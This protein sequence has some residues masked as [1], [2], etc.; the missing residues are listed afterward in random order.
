MNL[1]TNLDVSMIT[2]LFDTD[3]NSPNSIKKRAPFELRVGPFVNY[4]LEVLSF[5]GKER[6][7]DVYRYD[8]TFAT[9]VDEDTLHA[10]LFGEPGCLT[11]KAPGYD[12]RVI[13]G[14]V[15][16]VEGLGGV[17]GEQSTG[18]RRYRLEI[19]PKL[20]LMKQR[21][22]NRVFQQQSA[23]D[24]VNAMLT[25][26]GMQT[27]ESRWRAVAD[28]YPKLPFVYQRNE[29]DFD[30]FRRVLADAGIFFYFEHASALL[31]ILL[32]S[33]GAGVG[34]S[35]GGIGLSV[36]VSVGSS[37]TGGTTVLNFAARASDTPSVVPTVG[38]L[39]ASIGASLGVSVG[40]SLGVSVGA[41]GLSLGAEVDAGDGAVSDTITFDDGMG[42]D[43]G[44]DK[45]YEFGVK[46]LLRTK[47]LRLQERL[48]DT[49]VNW[50][51][52]QA[53][54]PPSS[55]AGLSVAPS[56]SVSIGL[57]GISASASVGSSPT[58]PF[59]LD[60]TA[61][62]P[63][64][65]RQERYQVDPSLSL[66]PSSGSVSDPR[67]ELEL[68]RTRRRY[69][70]AHGKSDC[71]RL[72]AGYRFTL[73]G[74]PIQALNEEY[75]V[76]SLD[77]HG[78]HPDYAKD[79]DHVYRNRFR[80]IPST[81]API[82]PRP[83]KRP[84]LGIEMAQVVAYSDI[85]QVPWLESSPN[86][87]VKIRFRWDIVDQGGA[88]TGMLQNGVQYSS[89][90]QD[91]FAI[92]V[93]VMQPWAGAG[94]GA[95]FIPRE[96]MEVVVGFLEDQGERPV[97]LGCMYNA[98][99]PPP[100]P[101]Q[102]DQ[103]KVGIKSQTRV[104][105]GGWSEVS[106]DDTQGSEDLMLRAQMDMTVNVL[107][108]VTTTVGN[109]VTTTIG[110]DEST[111][112]AVDRT[113][114]VGGNDTQTVTGNAARTVTGTDTLAV[115]GDAT[116]TI[117]GNVTCS[118][119]GTTT[120]TL[121]GDVTR[122]LCGDVLATTSGKTDQSFTLDYTERHQG[123]RTVIV[124]TGNAQRSS[125]LHVEGMGRAYASTSFEV[126]VLTGFTLVCGSS[127]ILVS[128]TGI[129]LSSPNITLSGKEVDALAGTFKANVS[130]ALTMMADTATLETSGAQIA[131]DSSSVTVEASAIKLGSGS[132]STSQTSAQPVKITKVQMKDSKGVPRA[133]TRV[134][135]VQGGKQRM[136]VLDADGMLE[137]IGDSS[138]QI[139]FPD[140]PQAK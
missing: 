128:P 32:P 111:S 50:V 61:V 27:S 21:R 6:V 41:G 110:N 74:Y 118:V 31:D 80:C 55:P 17:P 106:I 5:R 7:N 140:D 91:A 60:A 136:T 135:L 25:E 70:E 69:L 58:V 45:I 10:S 19:V 18:W 96:G 36:G 98:V 85:A 83:K 99:N 53:V 120:E 132:G 119:T 14:I 47:A 108:D 114:Q 24:I 126:E 37:A 133:D 12:N 48:V 88:S 78:I 8:V 64:V 11:I 117:T 34:A 104:A 100:W 109:D 71:R 59:D 29:S 42:A 63:A 115:T 20:W 82:P 127:Q 73:T 102:S 90:T 130:G 134:L 56:V 92:W 51:G 89:G 3:P 94:Y 103:Q 33:A 124:G 67:M 30:F 46:K 113:L 129:T 28:D 125:T 116:T 52:E 65:L 75:T 66:D 101:A 87:Y 137:L 9:A 16:S 105:D 15:A 43:P 84:K 95:Q 123:H 23:P 1:V 77:A 49:A 112:I 97:I 76:V 26:V 22:K 93:P 138:Y 54:P 4:E 86:G 40:A 44:D 81:Y 35:L 13:Q 122:T 38:G 121:T 68:A 62:T 39:S 107:N 2:G 72:G 139:S 57:G 79:S 131:L